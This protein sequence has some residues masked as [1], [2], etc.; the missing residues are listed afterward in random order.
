MK[1]LLLL[2][3]VSAGALTV[4]NPQQTVIPGSTFSV[5]GS[6]F[7]V[8]GGNVGIGTTSPSSALNISTNGSDTGILVSSGATPSA[9]LSHSATATH[10]GTLFLYSAGSVV[11]RFD[12]LSSVDSYFNAG[13]FGIGSDITPDARLE[14][15]GNGGD[16]YALLVSSAD[17]STQLMFVGTEGTAFHSG[18]VGL[19]DSTPDGQLDILSNSA[20]TGFIVSVS[21]QNDTTGAL[22]AIV[23][24]GNIGIGSTAPASALNISTNG[25]DV[26][27][28]VS[29]GATN[30]VLI[31]HQANATHDGAIY[32]YSAGAVVA[33]IDGA[34][35]NDS[36]LNVGQLGIGSD[37]SPD[38]RLEISGTGGDPY[39]VLVTS[40]NGSTGFFTVG[41]AGNVG[42]GPD[43]ALDK[44]HISSGTIRFAGSGTPAT[45]QALC[46]NATGQL[47]VC[48]SLVG[49][50][51]G[52]TCN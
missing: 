16:P 42:I 7:T 36:Y 15:V 25:S 37:I 51:G 13:Q 1:Y 22:F 43:T 44:L 40:A 27:V 49:A 45:A 31:A 34:A 18:N 29:S 23:G 4:Q 39:A 47:A 50:G 21:S 32:V 26:G 17:G 20:P 38:A 2:L 6:T 35:G 28:L 3:A 52:C 8:V 14:V 11:S 19:A 5:G 46:I 41:T 48:S 33:R 10:D 24:N 30:S 9:L 12:G